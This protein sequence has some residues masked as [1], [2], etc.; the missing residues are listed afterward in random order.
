MGFCFLRTEDFKNL[1]TYDK[2]QKKTCGALIKQEVTALVF[3]LLSQDLT[4]SGDSWLTA[5]PTV[6]FTAGGDE[7]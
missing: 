1:E 7:S 6:G 2:N 5:P 3:W 4:F